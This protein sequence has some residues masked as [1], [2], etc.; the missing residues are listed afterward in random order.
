[1]TARTLQGFMELLPEEQIVMEKMKSVIA[2]T[3]ELFGFA[4]LDTPVLELAEVLLS[5]S[6]GDTEKQIY[7]FKKGDTNLAMRFDLTVPLA[8]YVALYNNNLTFPFKRYQIG[9][10]YRG[11]RP[12]KGRFR[13]FYQCDIDIIDRDELNIVYD[14]EVL[15]VIYTVFNK[16]ELPAFKIYINNRKLLSGFLE[17]LDIAD[18]TVDV[19][20]LVDKIK[21][22]PEEAFLGE[23]N[24][25]GLPQE[26]NRKLLEFIK[27]NGLNN[28][29]IAKLE[30]LNI[31]NEN[32]VC[33][34]DELK[35][36]INQAHN[37]GINPNNIQ[38]DLSIT[39]GLDYYTGTVYETFFDDYPQFGSVCSGGRYDNLSSVFMDKKFPGVGISIGL[40]R[41]FDQLRDNG[42][43]KIAGST[44]NKV[45]IITQN[46]DFADKAINLAG[47][48]RRNDIP[49][50]VMLRNCKFKKK[51]EYANKIKIPYLVIIGEEEIQNNT[52]TI[53]DMNSGEQHTV[54]IDELLGLIK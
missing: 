35:T 37:L 44:P 33:G 2:H 39:R 50:D 25:M 40:T 52:Y 41:L 15:A 5:K 9:K 13:E 11:E 12:Q 29:I 6:G 36:V 38:I 32:F 49:A 31:S 51:M 47:E 23:L 19:L 45:L 3:Y 17:S 42:L 7:E 26:K 10:V 53:K 28:E 34:L 4:P 18:K 16:L 22:I 48:L 20:R 27:I 54:T 30:N 46:P 8:K 21:K 43:L 1:M 24:D 14:A